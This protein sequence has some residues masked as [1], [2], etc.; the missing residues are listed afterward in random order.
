MAFLTAFPDLS[1]EILMVVAEGDL[2]AAHQ[3]WRGTHSAEFLG[4]AA[5]GKAV[6]FTSTAILR[7]EDGMI[8]EAWDEVDFLGLRSRL[9]SA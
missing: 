2:V 9:G 1:N 6:E 4:V 7:V 5:T 8:A 3:R